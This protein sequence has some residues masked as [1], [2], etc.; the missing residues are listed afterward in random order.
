MLPERRDELVR[1]QDQKHSRPPQYVAD[2]ETGQHP[3]VREGITALQ[4][5]RFGAADQEACGSTG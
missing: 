2:D 1:S 3:S 4:V 5:Q